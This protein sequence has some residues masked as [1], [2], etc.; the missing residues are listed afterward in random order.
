MHAQH[1]FC[2]LDRNFVTFMSLKFIQAPIHSLS[3]KTAI[4]LQL[5]RN[6]DFLMGLARETS[7][8]QQGNQGSSL[9]L[10]VRH[11]HPILPMPEH[12]PLT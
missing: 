9:E 3:C 8:R 11:P 4:L 1:T 5:L 10:P 2:T 12:S 7:H 6:P